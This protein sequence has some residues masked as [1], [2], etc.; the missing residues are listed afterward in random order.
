M[1]EEGQFTHIS[2]PHHEVPYVIYNKSTS[3]TILHGQEPLV[4]AGMSRS[5]R[6]LP[7]LQ[8]LSPPYMSTLQRK[9]PSS[10]Y[11]YPTYSLDNEQVEQ[12]TLNTRRSV[13]FVKS[14][15]AKN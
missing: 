15:K 11:P 5:S 2:I 14:I 3:N 9:Q 1:Q 13:R 4:Y 7:C 10:L 12:V 6:I 8:T